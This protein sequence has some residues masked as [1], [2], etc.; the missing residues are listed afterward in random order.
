MSMMSICVQNNTD[1]WEAARVGN[2]EQVKQ[3]ID[4]GEDVNREN[5]RDWRVCR[6][7][8]NCFR[9]V[10]LQTGKTHPNF[11]F[12]NKSP[13]V[14]TT[15]LCTNKRIGHRCSLQR[16][17]DIKTWLNCWSKVVPIWMHRKRLYVWVFVLCYIIRFETCWL[18]LTLFLALST[19]T[20][21]CNSLSR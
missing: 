3:L 18:N 2:V 14:S 13:Y 4:R 9:D 17:M 6:H 1:I 8:C 10:F 16:S 12:M 7:N 11:L 15:M 20:T 21:K 5:E 19:T